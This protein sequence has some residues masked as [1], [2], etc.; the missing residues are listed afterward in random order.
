MAIANYSDLKSTVAD[1]LNRSDITAVIP[2]F[3]TLAE[4]QISGRLLKE[5]PVREMMGRSDSTI[6]SEFI[7]VP[8]DFL[9]ANAM[10]LAPNYLPI[11]FVSPEEI[12]QRKTLY[13]NESGD[14]QCFSVV[15]TEFQF[16]PWASGGTFDAELTYW[17]AIPALSDSN[18][19]N[20][21]LTKRPD[22]YLYTTLIQSAPYLKDDAR[23]TV[24]GTLATTG[25]DDLMAGDKQ[26]RTAPHLSVG[27]VP[28]GTP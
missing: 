1:F 17:K 4:A 10:Y 3:I 20:W 11:D 23:L 28:G 25:L 22:V 14:P 27:I 2:T 16:W 12:V 7:G 13:P 6:N 5:G 8:D 24:W 26:A 18:P 9:A 15:G 21:L 19:T